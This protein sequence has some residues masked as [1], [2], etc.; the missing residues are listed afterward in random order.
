MAHSRAFFSVILCLTMAILLTEIVTQGKCM[1]KLWKLKLCLLKFSIKLFLVSA[2]C[3]DKLDLNEACSSSDECCSECCD[4]GACAEAVF[5]EG[6]GGA[7]WT[8]D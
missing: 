4:Y 6:G 2:D 5:C 7:T 8:F 3:S 1:R